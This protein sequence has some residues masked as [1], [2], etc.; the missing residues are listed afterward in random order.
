MK[1]AKLKSRISVIFAGR[2]D[3]NFVRNVGNIGN[4]VD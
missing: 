2:V 3:I 4:K 1:A